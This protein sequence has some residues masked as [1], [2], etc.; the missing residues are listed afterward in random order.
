L[1]RNKYNLVLISKSVYYRNHLKKSRSNLKL[2]IMKKLSLF[3][4]VFLFSIV[5]SS[6]KTAQTTT[7]RLTIISYVGD[8]ANAIV[9]RVGGD[10]TAT[11]CPGT[12]VSCVIKYKDADGDDTTYSSKKGKNRADIEFTTLQ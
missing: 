2:K 7:L 1:H 10:V 5:F 11:L 3:F 9:H 12:G 4:C 6:F 8:D